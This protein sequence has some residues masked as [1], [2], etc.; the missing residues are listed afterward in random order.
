MRVI[1]VALMFLA[2][3]TSLI[4]G[5]AAGFEVW[6]ADD[7]IVSV[8]GH[9]IDIQVQMPVDKLLA[10]RSTR[11]T[12]IIPRNVPGFVLLD[13]ISAFPMQTTVVASDPPWAGTGSLPVRVMVDVTAALNYPVRVAAKPVNLSTLL[14]GPT[15][16]TGTANIRI[17]LRLA[18]G[19]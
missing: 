2:L 3:A 18:L 19:K 1:A 6:C 4:P 7:P 13:D 14:S 16:A 5:R 10:M 11:L 9:L 12:V 8:G 15:T 17:E